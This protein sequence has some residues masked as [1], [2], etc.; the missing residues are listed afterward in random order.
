MN[1]EE[2]LALDHQDSNDVIEVLGDMINDYYLKADVNDLFA[3]KQAS[4]DNLYKIERFVIAKLLDL[5]RK[6]PQPTPYLPGTTSTTHSLA[7]KTSRRFVC[8][9][10]LAEDFLHT[11]SKPL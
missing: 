3:R 8:G 2:W 5:L 7:T 6:D 1:L 10:C 11:V 4:Q 9:I